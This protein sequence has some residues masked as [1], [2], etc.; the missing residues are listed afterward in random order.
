MKNGKNL[1][2]IKFHFGR[3]RIKE[4]EVLINFERAKLKRINLKF[5]FKYYKYFFANAIL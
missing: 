2:R 1:R 5:I 4:L 3:I